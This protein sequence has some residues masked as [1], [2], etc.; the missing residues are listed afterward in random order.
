[1]GKRK[2]ADPE[3]AAEIARQLPPDGAAILPELR[4][5]A[6][7]L[8]SPEPEHPLVG[9]VALALGVRDGARGFAAPLLRLAAE[10]LA[11][12][13]RDAEWTA[14]DLHRFLEGLGP[15]RAAAFLDEVAEAGNSMRAG[16]RTGSRRG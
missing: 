9:G 5:L 3:L 8:R 2:R 13:V 11:D 7:E 14:E 15:E 12:Q 4:R 1:M 16:F 6:E 10:M